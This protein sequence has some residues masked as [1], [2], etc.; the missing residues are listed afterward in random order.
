MNELYSGVDNLFIAGFEN[1]GIYAVKGQPFGVIFGSRFERVDPNDPNSA[2]LINDDPSD[3]GFGMPIPGSKNDIVGNVNPDWNGSAL[4]NLSY[5]GINF[6]FQIDIRHGGDI[7]NGT[8][9]ALSYFG[10]SKESEIRGETK[11][12]DGN[13]GH[14]DV[15]GNVVHF[16]PDNVTE[17]S[18][19]G[20]GNTNVA[21][22]NQFYWQNIGSSFIGPAEPSVEDGSFVRIRQISLGYSIPK[23]LISKAHIQGLTITVFANNAKLWT[24]YKGVD[25]ETSLAGPANGQGLDYFNN[26][27]IKSYG[28][29]LNVSF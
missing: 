15:D 1:G 27:G 8:R 21:T 7:W 18:G 10:T 6:S 12:F 25:P 9:G 23:S 29:R 13:L 22:L 26:P 24:K 16:A 2:Y 28:V 4:S 19:A 14:I 3:P 5:K 17:L 20:G 11:T